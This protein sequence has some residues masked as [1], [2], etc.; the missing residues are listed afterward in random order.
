MTGQKDPNPK[1]DTATAAALDS[2]VR[3]VQAFFASPKVG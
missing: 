1:A 3:E 2:I